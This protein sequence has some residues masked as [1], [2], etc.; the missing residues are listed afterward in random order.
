[1]KGKYVA[2]GI[3]AHVDAGKTTLSESIL[4]E[5][6]VTR[7]LGRVDHGNA[8]L[9][10]HALERQRGI[11]IFSKQAVFS[12]GDL[13]VTL[14]DTPGH[15]DFS[16]EMERTL[17]VLDYAVLVI[18][19]G[20]GITGHVQT[21]WKLLETYG[22]PTFVFINKTDLA[23]SDRDAVLKQLADVLSDGLISFEKMDEAFYE[24][25]ALCDEAALEMLLSE[26]VISDQLLRIMI[27][28][29]KLFPVYSG[30]A[31]KMEGVRPFLDGL[32]QYMEAPPY[33]NDF[34]A[35]VYKISRDSQGKRLTHLKITGGTLHVRDTVGDEKIT[36]LR[37]Y[38]GAR[39][40][41]ADTASAG[42]ICAVCGLE[43]TYSGQGLGFE[44]AGAKPKLDTIL[45]YEILLPDGLDPYDAYGKFRML[46][47]EIPELH[48]DWNET[49]RQIRIQLMGE[50][51][52]EILTNLVSERFGISIGLGQ[53]TINYK[54]TISSRV[55]GIGHFEPL[56]HYAEVHLIL[57]PLSAGSGLVLDTDCS[58][59]LLDRNWQNLILTHL[60][61]REHPGVL[62]GSPITDMK[63]TLVSGKAHVK[64]TEGGD[65]RQAT[66]RAVRHGLRRAESVLLEPYYDYQLSVPS[67][68]VG[69]A[70]SDMQRIAG[71]CGQPVTQGDT[72]VLAGRAPVAS[73]GDYAKDVLSYTKGYGQL[74]LTYAGYFPC[75][76][77]ADVIAE[78][79]YDPDRDPDNPCG[80]VFCSHGGGVNVPWNEVE[81]CMHLPACLTETKAAAE[82]TIRRT[83]RREYSDAELEAVFRQTYGIS[84]REQN[85]F[86]R[87]SRVVTASAADRYPK[88]KSG[89]NDSKAQPVLL[90][91]GYNVIFA[92]DE[93][94]EMSELN[95]EAARSLLIETLQNYQGYTGEAMIVVFDAYKQPGNIGMTEK[96][97][98]LT[99]VYT[100]EG[101][102]ADQYIE[103]YVLENV[104]KQKITVAT[105]DGLEQMMIFGQGAL[106][107]P[108]RELQ[109]RVLRASQEIRE[110]YLGK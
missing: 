28:Q 50:V 1:M 47:E 29:R 24:K 44:A 46:E 16:A 31:L 71:A 37:I 86:N 64:H 11:T 79:G 81:S 83:G 65:F 35:R 91:D 66:Y 5:Q 104:K 80:S 20:D 23:G 43:S 89:Y 69:R 58:E 19:A 85:R 41:A 27:K 52:M 38:N 62:T 42:Q 17:Q 90:I 6:G 3:L 4:Y 93:L 70:M 45:S 77:A 51:Q 13:E 105:S 68:C 32:A 76:D 87:S 78:R 56:R 95:L 106:R 10:T 15:A 98:Q 14:L 7:S 107:M 94:K 30:S 74:Q 12:L 59:D 102:T 63:I 75:K 40:D 34:G 67:N 22:V 73:V 101:Q 54:E 72:A 108:A 36:Q 84:K 109:E 53:P 8:F 55:E 21:L 48:V 96:Y 57:E 25:A 39:F 26:G 82:E 100:R 49:S 33:P 2:V 9:D 97:G 110:K 60:A 92:W 61:E 18:S 88:V 99:V 103:K